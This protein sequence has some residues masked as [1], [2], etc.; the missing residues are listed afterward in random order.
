MRTRPQWQTAVRVSALLVEA[1]LCEGCWVVILSVKSQGTEI[2]KIALGESGELLKI[3][4]KLAR[5]NSGQAVK[6]QI[7]Q[8]AGSRAPSHLSATFYS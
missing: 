2:R 5:G 7:K 8:N 1:G 3:W 4:K 6:G